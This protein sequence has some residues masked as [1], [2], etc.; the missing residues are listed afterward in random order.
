MSAIEYMLLIGGLLIVLYQMAES[1]KRKSRKSYCRL[2]KAARRE[3][4]SF[5]VED[6]LTHSSSEDELQVALL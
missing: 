3:V 2:Y 5:S 1:D 6:S 4:A